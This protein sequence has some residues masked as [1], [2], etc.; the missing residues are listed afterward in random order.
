[1]ALKEFSDGEIHEDAPMKCYMNCIFH[2]FKVVDDN[3]EVH[4]DKI[5]SHVDAWDEEV[6]EIANGFL[7]QCTQLEGDNQ[8]ERAFSLHK[9]W[10]MADPK[11]S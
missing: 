3:G 8:C 11:V 6:R 2:E 5:Q 9:C 10:K 1:M 4:F 7:K